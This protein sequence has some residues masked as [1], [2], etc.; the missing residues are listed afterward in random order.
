MGVGG[1]DSWSANALPMPQY[2]I[3]SGSPMSFRYRL[4]PVAGAFEAKTREV[5]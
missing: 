2:R 1:I 3:D 4:A 5:F